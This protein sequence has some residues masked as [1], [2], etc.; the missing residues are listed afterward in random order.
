MTRVPEEP[1]P[2]GPDPELEG[3]VK[4]IEGH[5]RARRGV[6][7]ILTPRDFALARGWCTAGVPLATVLVGMDRAFESGAN[8]TSLSYCR[9]W[10]EELV[11][12]GPAPAL[13]PAPPAESIPLDEVT[14]LLAQLLEQLSRVRPRPGFDP[15]LRKIREVQDLLSVASRPNWSYVR[16]K[17]REIDDE[18]ARAA[19]QALSAQ[20]LQE[21]HDEATRAIERHRGRVDEAALHDAQDRFT[22]QRARERLG[23]PRVSLV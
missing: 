15:P 14:E 20:E 23:L 21:L 4:A 2:S 18:V 7:H 19:L 16:A 17:L 3:Y 1:P 8:V 22:L 12:A 13:R 5:L 11:A 6:E 10:V 9:K